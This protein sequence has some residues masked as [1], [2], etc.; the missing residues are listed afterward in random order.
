MNKEAKSTSKPDINLLFEVVQKNTEFMPEFIPWY[1]EIVH[2]YG[3]TP[4]QGLVAGFIY[5]FCKT[6]KTFYFSNRK[7]AEILRCSEQTVTNCITKLKKLGF[8]EVSYMPKFRGGLIRFVYLNDG[9]KSDIFAKN[10]K[11]K[12]VKGKKVVAEA[13]KQELDD[14]VSHYNTVFN[15]KTKSTEGFE[16][17]Y[18]E[19]RKVYSVDE[20]KKAIENARKDS[21]W[22][23]KLTLTILFRRKNPNREDVD[24]IDKF[25]NIPEIQNESVFNLSVE[26]GKNVK[27]LMKNKNHFVVT[28]SE[29]EKIKE[30]LNQKVDFITINGVAI[31]KNEIVSI[32]PTS[33]KTKSQKKYYEYV[34][35]QASSI[36][37]E[38]Y[39]N[40]EIKIPDFCNATDFVLDLL[41][42][43]RKIDSNQKQFLNEKF[44]NEIASFIEKT[45]NYQEVADYCKSFLQS[46]SISNKFLEKIKFKPNS[47]ITFSFLKNKI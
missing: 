43:T 7:L 44:S 35:N 27:I 2:K 28:A 30:V 18:I 34:E 36:R 45:K 46:N 1:I 17:N 11:E 33:E 9:F 4:L 3:L 13:F 14:I 41:Y 31:R 38:P 23:D 37:F 5:F 26:P 39:K 40:C 21:F 29:F 8:I 25:L 47:N 20:I 6:S 12:V 15:K 16:R 32:E 10:E 42:A 19:W 22:R 24:Y